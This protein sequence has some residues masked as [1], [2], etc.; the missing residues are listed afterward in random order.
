MYKT[1]SEWPVVPYF[2][3]GLFAF[4]TWKLKIFDLHTP[5]DFEAIPLEEL[6]EEAE[7][8]EEAEE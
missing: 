8:V 1:F 3:W 7:E 6:E 5:L 2:Q 4:V